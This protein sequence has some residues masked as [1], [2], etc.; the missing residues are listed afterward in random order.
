MQSPKLPTAAAI[1]ATLVLLGACS[2]PTANLD[3]TTASAPPSVAAEGEA[4]AGF[5][6]VAAGGVAPYT[7]SLQGTWPAG[8]TVNAA[9]D[10]AGV[11][12]EYGIFTG[13]S[14]MAKDSRGATGEYS[15][16]GDLK[17]R[18]SITVE[19]APNWWVS[20]PELPLSEF[21][22]VRVQLTM[23]NISG[24]ALTFTGGAGGADP[25]DG[26]QAWYTP[27]SAVPLAM[28]MDT[29]P[30]GTVA[31]DETITWDV[32]MTLG[33]AVDDS[34]GFAIRPVSEALGTMGPSSLELVS[35]TVTATY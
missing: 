19:A 32:T 8:M 6:V 10:V 21:S 1:L 17:V 23:K 12:T 7:Y 15:L 2:A 25:R 14:V 35:A 28:R 29:Y 3:V 18:P 27:D 13:L 26:L 22:E 16:E 33:A 30:E 4:Y 5:R 11:P 20:A 34:M 31:A 24:T 9:G